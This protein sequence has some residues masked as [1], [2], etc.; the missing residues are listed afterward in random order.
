[1]V[2]L[3]LF[4]SENSKGSSNLDGTPSQFDF[5]WLS[6]VENLPDCIP[7]EVRWFGFGFGLVFVFVCFFFFEFSVCCLALPP[8]PSLLLWPLIMIFFAAEWYFLLVS[9]IE[10]PCHSCAAQEAL[11][12][13]SVFGW[14]WVKA[15]LT[16]Y[17]LLDIYINSVVPCLP[18]NN[19]VEYINFKVQLVFCILIDTGKCMK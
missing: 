2:W 11:S 8:G 3:G 14:C 16:V 4:Q 12:L 10:L 6:F 18:H 9:G 17:P 1:L 13:Q 15:L 7:L 19:F 5:L